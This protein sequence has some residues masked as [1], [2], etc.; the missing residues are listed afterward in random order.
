[1]VVML[2]Y[3]DEKKQFPDIP[4]NSFRHLK[5]QNKNNDKKEYVLCNLLL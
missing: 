3:T 5:Q 4:E 1:M 2:L